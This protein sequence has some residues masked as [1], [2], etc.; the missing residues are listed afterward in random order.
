MVIHVL[1]RVVT[2]VLVKV[3]L[4]SMV[5]KVGLIVLVWKVLLVCLLWFNPTM[6]DYLIAKVAPMLVKVEM[7][8]MVGRECVGNIQMASDVGTT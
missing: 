5:S 3:V 1:E 6:V 2:F 8:L 7:C 4:V